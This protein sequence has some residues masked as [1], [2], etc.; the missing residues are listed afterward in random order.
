MELGNLHVQKLA[1]AHFID[2]DRECFLCEAR[3]TTHWTG[4][5]LIVVGY[6]AHTEAELAATGTR[7]E[8]KVAGRHAGRLTLFR[9]ANAA[10]ITSATSRNV[11]TMLRR[12][13]EGGF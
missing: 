1:D 3:P 8:P 4:S 13:G 5:P 12:F 9:G 2:P 10:R 11:A 7:I 6:F